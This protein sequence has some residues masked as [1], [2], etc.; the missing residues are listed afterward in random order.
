MAGSGLPGRLPLIF[1]FSRFAALP[2]GNCHLA[3]RFRSPVNLLAKA[4]TFILV[5]RIKN[6]LGFQDEFPMRSMRY[7]SQNLICRFTS[8][9]TRLCLIIIPYPL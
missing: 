5:N 7:P 1:R 2:D 9:I 4:G 6:H 3:E 8:E